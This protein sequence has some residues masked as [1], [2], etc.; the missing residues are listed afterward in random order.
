MGPHQPLWATSLCPLWPSHAQARGHRQTCCGERC[1]WFAALGAASIR[2]A[3]LPGWQMDPETGREH[4]TVL[5]LFFCQFNKPFRTMKE[6]WW[7][8]AGLV[9]ATHNKRTQ[10]VF[11]FPAR[12]P[13]ARCRAQSCSLAS[14]SPGSPALPTTTGCSSS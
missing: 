14:P 12:V 6:N 3:A 9:P 7:T 13:G 8:K 5:L 1:C 11:F 10:R 4:L 2:V